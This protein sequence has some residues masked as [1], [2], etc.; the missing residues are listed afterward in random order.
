MRK[1]II[2]GIV[3]LAVLAAAIVGTVYFDKN[4]AIVES[5]YGTKRIVGID[6]TKVSEENLPKFDDVVRCT[7]S[8]KK[9]TKLESLTLVAEE[10]IDLNNLSEM[11][12]LNELSIIYFNKSNECNVRFETL[13]DLPN[14]KELRL[15]DFNY[16]GYNTNFTLSDDVEYNFDSIEMFMIDGNQILDFECFKHFKNLKLLQIGFDKKGLTEEQ[17]EELE[18]RGITVEFF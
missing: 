15:T 10:N 12:N 13:P 8:L 3:I 17:F 1:K 7:P 5:E 16:K 2:L 6:V 18:S 9:L 4:Y 11:K 14:L